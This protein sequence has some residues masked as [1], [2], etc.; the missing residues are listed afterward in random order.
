M[1]QLISFTDLAAFFSFLD[2]FYSEIEGKGGPVQKSSVV[3]YR[4][5]RK[6]H[7]TSWL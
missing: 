2:I 6:L 1:E 3:L 5:D 4:P 7:W